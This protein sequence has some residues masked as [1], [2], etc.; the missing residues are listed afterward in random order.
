MDYNFVFN[1]NN[2]W[3]SAL[4]VNNFYI[5]QIRVSRKIHKLKN[6]NNYKF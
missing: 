3:H 1:T 5:V 4:Y 2:M 6:A